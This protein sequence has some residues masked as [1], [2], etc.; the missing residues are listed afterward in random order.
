MNTSLKS[1]T[2]THVRT[3]KHGW[4]IFNDTNKTGIVRLG[5]CLTIDGNTT[6][7]DYEPGEQ[8]DEGILLVGH[9]ARRWLDVRTTIVPVPGRDAWCI[10]HTLVN[11]TGG[12]TITVSDIE[13]RQL[14]DGDGIKLG[15]GKD[16]DVRYCHSDNLR[17][18]RL[19][20]CQMD[21]PYVRPLPEAPRTLGQ[22]ED[23]PFPGLYLTRRDYARGIV[24]AAL[25]QDKTFQSYTVQRAPAP[26]D[27]VLSTFSVHHELPLCRGYRLG[28]GDDLELDGMYVQI[29][30]D[31][32]PEDA[33]E[34]YLDYLS[35]ICSFR[36]PR[37][38]M[39]DE[40][41]YC[42]WNYGRFSDQYEDNL[43][44]TARFMAGE[45]PNITYFLVDAGYTRGCGGQW[46]G[47]Q[48]NFND[49]FY[50]DPAEAVNLERFP[51]GM[52]GFADDIRSLGLKPGIWWSP[53]CRLD[54]SLFAEH[55]EWFL[56]TVDGELYTIGGE[57]GYL[58]LS[59]EEV[60]DFVNKVLSVVLRDWS[61]EALK[62][63]FWSQQFEDRDIRLAGDNWTALDS[64]KFL[65]DTIRKY[66]PDNGV[67][68]TCVAT[69][70]GNPF[71]ATHADTFRN[72]IDIGAG[73]WDEQIHACYWALPVL[74]KAG[75]RTYLH[76]N[77]SVGVNL[78]CPDNENFFRLTWC[79]ITMGIQEVGG[80]LEKLPRNYV[81]AMRVFTDNCDRGYRCLCPDEKA[82]RGEP[83]PEVLYVDYPKESRTF[84]GG[85]RKH[86]A[87]F[88]WGDEARLVGAVNQ[89]LEL[90]G[91]TKVRDV[92]TGEEKTFGADG[93]YEVL[94][95][96][97]AKLYAVEAA[98][99]R[100]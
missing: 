64:R 24:L 61:M 74:G 85:V 62:M 37:T 78:D 36:G 57:K 27:S 17:I 46:G 73:A 11:T 2:A 92:W 9:D 63:D 4:S 71:L 100:R 48:N 38:T 47:T 67:F 55:P 42:S 22:G 7:V 56:Y 72:T 20:H 75:R 33:F 99:E 41:F 52:K 68:M 15:E 5:T 23:Q 93:V 90:Q 91:E 1:S 26:G 77:D 84:K 16:W 34:D 76:N 21:L 31:T 66:L 81:D 98:K 69:G 3:D 32:H 83:L 65:F 86:V 14:A 82:W 51:R 80:F 35:S 45:M 97:T 30:E 12:R 25:G 54:T 59:I 8:L 89:R 95:A 10:Q 88:N 28:P 40:A 96:R 44:A 58:D 18:E 87:L 19:P 53:M 29:L 70:M 43:L 79:W 6:P 50:P 49:Q 94:P 39:L 60:R 13:T